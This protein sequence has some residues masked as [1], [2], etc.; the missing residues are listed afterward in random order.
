[1]R[2]SRRCRRGPSRS[3]ACTTGST[4]WSPTSRPASTA[5]SPTR[6]GSGGRSASEP[7]AR[8][9]RTGAAAATPVIRGAT[10][11]GLRPPA[12]GHLPGGGVEAVPDVDAGDGQQQPGQ[13][14]LV[15][16]GD[17]RRPDVVGDGVLAVGQAG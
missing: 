14:L 6:S 8:A 13:L 17:R 10:A 1:T 9:R 4:R 2:P 11:R 3:R 7:G 12:P 16:V 15:V 5:T